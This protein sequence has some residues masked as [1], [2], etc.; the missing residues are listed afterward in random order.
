[1]AYSNKN[2]GM[3]IERAVQQIME[4]DDEE[5]YRENENSDSDVSDDD[6]DVLNPTY[7][8]SIL[9]AY[10]YDTEAR[11]HSYNS[12]DSGSESGEKMRIFSMIY[13][14]HLLIH[15]RHLILYQ[16]CLP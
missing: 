14:Q 16:Q 6:D 15:L 12:T 10:H 5:I 2:D 3:N 8:P 13:R 9:D 4:E 11:I 1:M 7:A